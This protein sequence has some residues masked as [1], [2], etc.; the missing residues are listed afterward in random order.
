MKNIYFIIINYIF[1]LNLSA[2]DFTV[3]SYNCGALSNHYDYYRAAAMQK[4][5][6]ERYNAEPEAMA[7]LERIQ[8]VALKILFAKTTAEQELAQQTWDQ[9]GYQQIFEAIAL[10]PLVQSS[11]NYPWHIKANEMITTYHVRPIILW[12]KEVVQM[13]TDHMRDITRG[14][15]NNKI[16][17][18][19]LMLQGWRVMAERIFRHQLKYDIICLQE[20]DFLDPSMFPDG[21]QA[22]FSESL[23]DGIA[24]NTKRFEL[25]NVLGDIMGRGFAAKFRDKESGK[26]V[27]I[28]SGHITGCNPFKVVKDLQSDKTDASKGNDELITI[29]RL[30]EENEADIKMIGMDSNVTATHPR[31]KIVK[32]YGYQIDSENY[33]E[34]TCTNPY[35]ILDTRLDWIAV[36]S[37]GDIVA[38]ITNIPVNGV[39]LNSIQTN[40]SDHKPIA[41]RIHF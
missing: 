29:F 38:S 15:D 7:R 16:E 13:L 26:T 3:G 22:L 28:A 39:G 9:N 2:T 11:P 24:F 41:A 19:E 12:D 10:R 17:L 18:E 33:L 1:L 37:A 21:Y 23:A 32:E 40:I 25:V 35:Q 4:L 14:N 27:L 20:A 34:P 6:Q 5:M 31:L 36:K 30:L 8:E